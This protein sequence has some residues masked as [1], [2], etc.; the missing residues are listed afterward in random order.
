MDVFLS[1]KWFFTNSN[2]LSH[3]NKKLNKAK[4]FIH[5]F[6]QLPLSRLI[7]P[8]PHEEFKLER[9]N[10]I[11]EGDLRSLILKEVISDE[12][13]LF[14]VNDINFWGN[15]GYFICVYFS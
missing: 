11:F 10:L 8:K 9:R 12:K 3:K 6:L 13:C 4:V 15:Y 7:I 14:C 2:V 1:F 5:L